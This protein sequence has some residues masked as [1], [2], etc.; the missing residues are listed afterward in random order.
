MDRIA[1]IQQAF[2][3]VNIAYRVANLHISILKQKYNEKT[4][5]R[6]WCLVSKKDHNKVL[7][8]YGPKKPNKER[9]EK[10]EKRVQFF[11]HNK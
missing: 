10:T 9:V 2:S 6:E 5:Q 11:K 3:L 7:E 8:W 1:S 4:N